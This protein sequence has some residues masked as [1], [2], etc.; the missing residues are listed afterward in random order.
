[1][2]MMMM[3]MKTEFLLVSKE[4][5]SMLLFASCGGRACDRLDIYIYTV[6][7]KKIGATYFIKKG[8]IK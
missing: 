3:K 5:V 6:L 2:K 8:V 4:L 7:A 1:M